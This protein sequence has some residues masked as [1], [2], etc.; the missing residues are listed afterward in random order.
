[1][2]KRKMM[3]NTMIRLLTVVTILLT[4]IV[5]KG[6][7]QQSDE[8]GLWVMTYNIRFDNPDDGI[9]T[10]ENRK[11]R[12]ANLIRFHG[13]D[14]FGLQEA[15]YHQVTYLA[16]Q[17]ERFEWSGVG[18][19]DGK[20][21]GEFSPV[22]FNAGRF[23]KLDG[24]TFWLSD[25][26]DNPSTGWD[27][28]LPRIVSW[29]M[30][31]ERETGQDFFF[32]NTHFDHRGEEARRQSAELILKKIGEITGGDYPVLLGGDFNSTPDSEPYGVLTGSL[33]DAMESSKYPH[34]GPLSTF[35]ADGG[36]FYVAEGKGGVRIDYI[37]TNDRV[38]VLRHG[39]IGTFRDGRF[40][41]DHL[42]VI[43]EV[44]F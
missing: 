29:V 17:L 21:E 34:Y 23:V 7:A 14:L 32:F 36:P 2:I 27:A 1:M 33:N 40:P 13:A 26:P 31:R 18:R 24:G 35:M 41:S 22:F 8:D 3:L 39:I 30:L 38:D 12:V 4:L 10:W 37:F 6:T 42:P 44:Q 15:E 5:S 43:A 25:T 20:K 9:N 19:T 16:D 28:A 11:E